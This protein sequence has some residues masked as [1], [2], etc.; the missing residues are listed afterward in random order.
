MTRSY[1]DFIAV[2]LKHEGGY[3]NDPLDA[4][5]ETNYGISKRSYP[6]LDIKNMTEEDASSIYYNDYFLLLN[7]T[8]INDDLLIL[9]LFD[10]GVNVG[11]KTAVRLLQ[12]IVGVT[13]DGMIGPNSEAK[14]NGFEGDLVTLYIQARKNY[15]NEIVVRTPT[16]AKFLNGWLSRIDSTNFLN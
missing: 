7:P 3:V 14:I 13:P 8:S 6:G 4:G 1:N 16:N 15:Y 10:M 11:I 12:Q 9:H 5:G 2:I